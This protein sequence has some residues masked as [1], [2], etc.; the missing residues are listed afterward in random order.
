MKN[1]M[2]WFITLGLI[3]LATIGSIGGMKF[4]ARAKTAPV[5]QGQTTTV[6]FKGLIAK[7][8]SETLILR[9]YDQNTGGKVL[10]E[11][12][13]RVNISQGVYIAFAEVPSEILAANPSVWLEVV[14]EATPFTP[15]GERTPFV[16]RL[17]GGAAPRAITCPS[18]GCAS[19]CFTCGGAYPTFNGAFPL[20]AGSMPTER[21]SSCL[22]PLQGRA[23]TLPFLCTQ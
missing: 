16:T 5:R 20:P 19:L 9:V 14:S 6:P 17:G 22:D 2:R 11:T 13:Q 21:G 23:D 7:N 15:V 4:S 18:G 10:F 12:S 1:K 8:G 3:S